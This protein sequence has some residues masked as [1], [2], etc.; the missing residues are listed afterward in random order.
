MPGRCSSTC[1]SHTTNDDEDNND[2]DGD[3][4]VNDD[5]GEHDV[6]DDG[7]DDRCWAS[8][9]IILTLTIIRL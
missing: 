8:T 2:G 1:P 4:D 5:N 9:S 3:D 6:N 7:A